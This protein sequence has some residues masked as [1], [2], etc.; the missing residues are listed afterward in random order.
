[1]ALELGQNGT[2]VSITVL[3]A[4]PTGTINFN[5]MLQIEAMVAVDGQPPYPATIPTTLSQMQA[6]LVQPGKT[7]SGK[8]APDDREKIWLD[9]TSIR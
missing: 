5:V 3:S 9:P 6:P 1:M 8:V 2:P 4:T 7:F